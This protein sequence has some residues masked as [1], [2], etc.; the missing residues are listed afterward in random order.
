MSIC[1]AGYKEKIMAAYWMMEGVDRFQVGLVSL[2]LVK[3]AD[4]FDGVWPWSWMHTVRWMATS[5][6]GRRV[7]KIIRFEKI[8]L[9]LEVGNV[10]NKNQGQNAIHD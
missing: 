7:C 6:G 5:T 1:N 3:Y 2:H 10:T 4:K 9:I 8:V